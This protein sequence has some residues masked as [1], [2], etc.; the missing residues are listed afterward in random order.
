MKQQQK[1][2]RLLGKIEFGLANCCENLEALARKDGHEDLANIFLK[3]K[4][5]EKKHGDMLSAIADGDSR[6]KYSPSMPIKLILPNNKVI[7][8]HPEANTE[9][10]ES[11]WLSPFHGVEV[12]CVFEHLDGLSGKYISIKKFLDGKKISDYGWQDR[13]AILSVLECGAR[14]FY[15]YLID[16][17]HTN[18]SIRAISIQILDDENRHER[19]FRAILDNHSTNSSEL[20]KKWNYRASI[21]SLW[22]LL[23][24]WK[25]LISGK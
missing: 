18:E 6:V 14:T 23:D 13:L 19:D 21:A 24:A 25:Q 10:F 8:Y 5:E 9:V 11:S 7:N 20:I 15:L 2:L 17:S 4:K 1:F 22:L 3:H 16:S 12:K